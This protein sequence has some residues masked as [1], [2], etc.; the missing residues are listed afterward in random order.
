M[1]KYLLIFS[2]L[3][4]ISSSKGQVAFWQDE[5]KSEDNRLPMRASFFSYA[6]NEEANIADWEKSSRYKSLNGKWKFKYFES[7]LDLPEGYEFIDYQDNNWG[8][9]RVPANWEVNGYGYPVYVNIGYEFQHIFKPN[10]P[11]VPE[12]RNPTGVYRKELDIESEWL[13]NKQVFLHIGAAKSNLTVWINGVYVGYGE[14][15]KLASE[16]NVSEYLKPGKNTI[17]MKVMQWSDGTYLEGQDFWRVSG[18]TRDCYLMARQPL[19]IFDFALNPI[20]EDDFNKG[21]LKALFQLNRVPKKAGE[22]EIEV[23]FHDEMIAKKS[24]KVN[25]EIQE[26]S[27][28]ILKPHLWSAE[29][30][31]LYDVVIRL[32]NKNGR[33]LEVIPQRIGFRKV[34]IKNGQLLVNG[35]TVLIKGVNRHETHPVTGQVISKEDMLKDI[36][37]MKQ[38][39]INAVRT[40]HYPNDEY[41]YQLCD[42]YGIYVVDEANIESHGIGYK[43]TRTLGNRPNWYDAHLMRVKRMY[44]RDKNHASVIIWSL[45][46]EAGNGYNFYH[47]YQWLKDK[48]NSRPIQY[49]RTVDYSTLDAEWNTDIICPMYPSPEGLRRYAEKTLNPNRPLI[50]CEYA[51]AMG[52]SLGNFKDYWDIIR[53][54]KHALQGGFIWDFV[55]QSLIKTTKEDNQIYAYGGDYGPEG[56][57]SDNNFL[58]NGIFNPERLPN[59][60]AWEMKKVYQPV[61]TRLAGKNTIEI[62]NEH[63]FKDLSELELNYELQVD[64]KIFHTGKVENLS[65]PAGDAQI[66]PLLLPDAYNGEKFLNITYTQRKATSAIPAGHIVATEQLYL[67]GDYASDSDNDFNKLGS[68]KSLDGGYKVLVADVEFVFNKETGFLQ[69][70]KVGDLDFIEKNYS[71]MPDFWRAPTDNDMGANLQNKLAVW[72]TAVDSFQL[73]SFSSKSQSNFHIV[74]ALYSLENI[75]AQ[76]SMEYEISLDGSLKVR[77]ELIIDKTKNAPILPKFGM[78]YIMPSGFEKVEYY[79]RG[80][81]ENY[82]DRKYSAHVGIYKQT[83]DDQYYPYIRPQETGNRSGIRWFKIL[84][85]E[86]RGVK[87]EATNSLLNTKALHFFTEDLDDGEAK[88]QRHSGEL[89]PREQVQVN[90]DHL[91]MG[92]G[93]ID[94]WGAMPLEK[95]RIPYQAYTYTFKLIPVRN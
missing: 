82:E 14:D 4:I 59:P 89:T 81:Y 53:A 77:E 38:F 71:L 45:G 49:E 30:P 87:I 44:E 22:I 31:N 24:V 57:P 17:V 65:V 66:L 12:N 75:P 27:L 11:L 1:N 34:E 54:N 40:S 88:S 86:G 37:L 16:F 68:I 91:Q 20:L 28:T 92:V 64:G 3:F 48:D 41:W 35:E 26:V 56:T 7:P 70:Y 2:F 51:H 69:T 6:S 18:V 60:H 50:M 67:G 58:N 33:I 76:L 73:V 74:K 43:L 78:K 21:N 19:H 23:R 80:P 36:L 10:P 46:N 32:K 90:I 5:G 93:S 79:G 29:I 52:N 72:R 9:I 8:E 39:N 25:H 84:N 83:V 94:S 47:L 42:E 95:Y 63:A 62:I 61:I 15:G 85:K 55:D 13:E